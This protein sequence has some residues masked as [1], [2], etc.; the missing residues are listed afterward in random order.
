MIVSKEE[1]DQEEVYVVNKLIKTQDFTGILQ[2]IHPLSTFH[3]MMQYILTT[4][5][6]AGFGAILL[7]GFVGYYLANLLIRPL[8]DLRDS[9]LSIQKKGFEENQFLL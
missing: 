6:I 1:V 5:L 8:Q 9:M 7:A 4:M 2:L 3:S